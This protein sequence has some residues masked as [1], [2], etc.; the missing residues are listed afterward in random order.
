MA[1]RQKPAQWNQRTL[2]LALTIVLVI[3]L[4]ALLAAFA[5]TRRDGGV[6]STTVVTGLAGIPVVEYEIK[7]PTDDG[8]RPRGSVIVGDKAYIA[9]SEGARVAVLDLAQGSSAELT[10]IPIA[11]ENPSVPL[12]ARPQPTA[13]G[14]LS[15]GTLLVADAANQTIWRLSTDGSLLGTFP[16]TLDRLRSKL[17]SPVGL[18]VSGDEVYVSDVFDQ[19][20]KVYS[21]SGS[22]LRA[23]GAAGYFPGEFSYPNAVTVGDEGRV[24]VADSNNNRVQIMGPDGSTPVV[25]TGA[26]ADKPF[27]LPRAVA[28]DRFGRLH[29]VDTFGQDVVVFD[30]DNRYLF[31]YGQDAEPS[32][33]LN[34]PEGIAIGE[35]VV[36]VSD[37]GNGRVLV[38][39]Y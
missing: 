17:T 20:I 16:E 29:V 28:R 30:R 15:D 2:Y 36:V 19:R 37:G 5:L 25:L 8:F 18:W 32:H 26:S 13:V 38:Y 4:A 33:R 14:A 34:L 35:N 27:S 23:F 21:A 11:S 31:T 3:A 6:T 9:D 10:F 24:V 39:A 22:Y 7:P 12:K 1:F